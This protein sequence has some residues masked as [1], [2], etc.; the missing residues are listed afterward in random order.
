MA[1]WHPSFSSFFPHLQISA[2]SFRVTPEE[3]NSKASQ[4]Q[5]LVNEM[6]TRFDSLDEKVASSRLFWRGDAAD[7]YREQYSVLTADTERL[8][9]ALEQYAVKLNTIAG[10]YTLAESTIQ[11]ELDVLP[12]DVIL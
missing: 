8:L 6:R 7:E 9:A 1:V 10:N 12:A 11:E 3:L 2:V 5:Q 4:V